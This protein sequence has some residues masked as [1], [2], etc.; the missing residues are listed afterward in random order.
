M[1]IMMRIK[2]QI[3]CNDGFFVPFRKAYETSFFI[4]EILKSSGITEPYF[5]FSP[6][7]SMNREIS[8]EGILLKNPI[9]LYITSPL[10]NYIKT[11]ENYFKENSSIRLFETDLKIEKTVIFPQFEVGDEENKFKC[12]SPITVY[13]KYITKENLEKEI[14]LNPHDSEFYNTIR[15]NLIEKFKRLYGRLPQKTNLYIQFDKNYL[16]KKKKI[17][18]LVQIKD[19]KYKAWLSPFT[20]SG[21]KEIIQI[22]YEWGI[23]QLNS[24]GL[25]MIEIVR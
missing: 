24:F 10:E 8:D 19:K 16:L 15:T 7:R 14:F 1:L 18:K 13:K 11:I 20:M 3:S 4:R 5:N 2:I 25:G 6:F 23:G 22:A 9:V 21:N 12:L 17:S